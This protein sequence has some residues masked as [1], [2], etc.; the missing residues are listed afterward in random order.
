MPKPGAET[1]LQ[2]TESGVRA[3]SVKRIC[4]RVIAKRIHEVSS[5]SAMPMMKGMWMNRF[6]VLSWMIQSGATSQIS[7]ARMMAM[8]AMMNFQL[9]ARAYHFAGTFQWK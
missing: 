7:H 1:V 9:N 4:M 8:N 2:R 6:Q 5:T 3:C